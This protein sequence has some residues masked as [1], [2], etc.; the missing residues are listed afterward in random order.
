MPE[1]GSSGAITRTDDAGVAELVLSNPARVNAI[2]A[3]MWA[4]LT[5]QLRDISEDPEVQVVVL[6]GH[7]GNFT[8]GLDLGELL[9]RADPHV[10]AD[11]DLNRLLE[12]SIRAATLIAAMPKLVIVEVRGA[13]LG[14]GILLFLSCDI[15]FVSDD[16]VLRFPSGH[17]GAGLFGPLLSHLV[18]PRRAKSLLISPVASELSG[19]QLCELGL[20]AEVVGVDTLTE[21]VR[22]HARSLA[23]CPP[24]W[25]QLQKASIDSAASRGGIPDALQAGAYFDAVA[26]SSDFARAAVDR[27]RTDRLRQL[28]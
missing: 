20:A 5:A 12:T 8:S 1:A 22:E 15:A 4:S 17:M 3:D 25:L 18:G 19:R 26:H 16:A 11:V 6:R 9:D 28:D 10:S 7:G 27:L 13:C 21:R 24:A 2:T 14:V 23:A